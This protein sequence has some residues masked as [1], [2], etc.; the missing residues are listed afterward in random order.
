MCDVYREEYVLLKNIHKWAKQGFFI[1]SLSRKDSPRNG[2]H[3]D[4]SVKKKFPTQKPV[5]KANADSL[6]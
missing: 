1:T 4:C 6:F 3:T 5:K 2:K